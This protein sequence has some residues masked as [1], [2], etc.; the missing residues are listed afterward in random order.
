MRSFEVGPDDAGRRLDVVLA[1]RLATSRSQA[2]GMIEAG[3]VTVDGSPAAKSDRPEPGQSVVVEEPTP[4]PPTPPPPLP[5]VRWR[6]EHLLV[7]AKPAGL[8]VHPG[9]GHPDGTLVD[10]LEAAGIPLARVGGSHRPG[11]V[12]RLDKGTSGL[13]VVASTE[14]AHRGLTD[15]LRRREVTRRYLALAEGRLGAGHGRVEGPVGR[16]PARRTRMGVVAG[17]R[18]AVTHWRMLDHGRLRGPGAGPSG[19]PDGGGVEA[20]PELCLLRCRLETGR[21]HQIRV[22]LSEAGHP[23]VGDRTYGAD[24]PLAESLGLARPFLHAAE[25]AFTHPVTGVGIE[26][27]EPLPDDL[28][29]ALDRVGL[30]V[31]AAGGG[32][33]R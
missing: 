14:A 7:V 19:Q 28:R 18:P 30:E 4:T 16:D 32:G 22:H 5:P 24:A 31:P 12:H 25:L 17:G 10:A 9:A 23:V 8:V 6:D 2:A 1:D 33:E 26:L 13:L 29:G 27:S 20:G 15:A 3:R 21:T 11:I